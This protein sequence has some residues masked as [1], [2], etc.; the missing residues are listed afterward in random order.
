MVAGVS[1]SANHEKSNGTQ[2]NPEYAAYRE[3][4]RWKNLRRAV[5]LRAKRKCEICRRR[6]GTDLAHL[7]YDRMFNELMTD[8]L[9]LCR[10]CHRQLDGRDGDGGSTS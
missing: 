10:A 7:T 9:W 1:T 8:V 5:M 2:P 4:D 3:T 6:D